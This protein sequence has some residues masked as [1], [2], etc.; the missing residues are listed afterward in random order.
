[1]CP[2]R[3]LNSAHPYQ[4]LDPHPFDADRRALRAPRT[5]EL[6]KALMPRLKATNDFFIY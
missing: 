5:P 3:G 1:M 2:L 4:R 6:R